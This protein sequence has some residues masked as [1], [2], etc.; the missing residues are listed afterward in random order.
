MSQAHLKSKPN[1]DFN[2][3]NTLYATHGLH[4]YAAKCPPQLVKFGIENYSK[5]GDTILDPM[6]GSGTTLVEARLLGRQY[7]LRIRKSSQES[8]KLIGKFFIVKS[9]DPENREH[10]R[11]MMDE[12]Y[13]EHA[14]LLI[15]RRARV[16]AKKIMDS[17]FGLIQTKYKFM[18][19]RWGSYNPDGSITFNVEL[20]KTPINCVNY[21]IVHELC[22]I[23]HPNHDKAFY[24][25]L[26]Q[27]IPGWL[28]VKE[29]LEI[30]GARQ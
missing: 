8:V 7:R 28:N 24:R 13:V 11:S 20:V 17:D 12:W 6:A 27:H 23:L 22:H 4:A 19:R 21:V 9:K 25:T 30:F 2:D 26:S 15:D 1:L 3:H 14:K 29:K 5:V 10:I 16:Y 18:K